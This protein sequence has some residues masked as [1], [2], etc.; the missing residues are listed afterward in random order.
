LKEAIAGASSGAVMLLGRRDEPTDAVEEYCR[1]LGDALRAHSIET[2]LVRVGWS[3]RG[4]PSSLKELQN[5]A[6]NWRGR[7]VLV[8]YTAL[9]WSARGFPRE[10]L[11]VL[12]VL[13]GVGARVGVVFHDVEPFTGR[14]LV[15]I[16]RRY[17]Q[18]SVMRRIL[19]VADLAIFTVPF[20]VISWLG[21]PPDG[22]AFIP[23]GAN[24]ADA[25]N[26]TSAATASNSGDASASDQSVTRVAVYGI[27]GGDA[28]TEEC[29]EIAEGV[30]IAAQRGVRLALH[31]IGR[32]AAEREAEL[33]EKLKGVAV[34]LRFDGVFP[35]ERVAEALRAADATLF[36]RGAISTRRGSAIAGI[37]CGRPVIAYGG[38]ETAPPVTE[39]G[40]MLI[41]RGNAAELGNALYRIA[42][43]TSYRALLGERSRT[44]YEKYFAWSAIARRYVEVLNNSN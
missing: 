12:S 43:D 9:A 21:N 10:F 32:G 33:R 26:E 23:V 4:W 28:G 14:R 15:D 22:A 25:L 20:T 35:A 7:W 16:L 39:A 13:R 44:A 42:S 2:E 41:S 1:Y 40:V 5:S 29:A 18:L 38:A 11:K 27:T 36:V 37:A 34:E 3:E 17:V 6:Q 30:R 24:L 8:Q 19:R 31:A